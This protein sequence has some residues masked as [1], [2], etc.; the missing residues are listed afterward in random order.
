MKILIG[1]PCYDGTVHL[2][3]MNSYLDLT[4]LCDDN[5]IE[6]ALMT[7]EGSPVD[8]ARNQIAAR[9]VND[10]SFT[11]LL[12][13]DSDMGWSVET[14][15]TLLQNSDLH[16]LGVA[17][18]KKEIE[19]KHNV[20]GPVVPVE[21]REGIATCDAVGTGIMLIRREVLDQLAEKLPAYDSGGLCWPFFRH[22]QH[23]H[24]MISEDF[25]FCVLWTALGGK[26]H[27]VVNGEVKHR[28]YYSFS[29]GM[30][31]ERGLYKEWSKNR[32]F[33]M[34]CQERHPTAKKWDDEPYQCRL[35][36]GHRGE[37][38]FVKA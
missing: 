16:I 17:S 2:I 4:E 37:H 27:A 38:E 18:P 14:M 32:P 10:R 19:F 36:S 8:I 30:H 34:R 23:G 12:F 15:R 13:I 28:G 5:G 25:N 6:T 26:V 21:G 29:Y 35:A 11:H 1:T 9:I 3:Y 20:T 24:R 31:E 22:E 7:V 33:S